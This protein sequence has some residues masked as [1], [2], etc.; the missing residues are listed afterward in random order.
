[1][2]YGSYFEFSYRVENLL[3]KGLSCS[4]VGGL[5]GL[6][7]CVAVLTVLY[8]TIKLL[9]Y[10]LAEKCKKTLLVNGNVSRCSSQES[11]TNRLDDFPLLHHHL[12]DVLTSQWCWT[13]LETLRT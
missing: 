9:R 13:G 7:V 2:P 4:T 6:C 12:F 10:Y 1:M 3:F 5:I 8:E 11:E